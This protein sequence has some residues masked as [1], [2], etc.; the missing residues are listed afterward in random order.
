ME[1]IE[2][3]LTKVFELLQAILS[4]ENELRHMGE[5]QLT[6][7]KQQDPN[8]L[9]LCLLSITSSSYDDSTRSLS[10][11][12]LRQM[13]SNGEVSNNYVWEEIRPE[14]REML[15]NDILDL[16]SSEQNPMMLN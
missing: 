7:L 4:P 6:L 9:L 10:T 11:V 12:I 2:L 16:I 15:Q 3:H 13:V 8:M 14:V 1:G 5:Q